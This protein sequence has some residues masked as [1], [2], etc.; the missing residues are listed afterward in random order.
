[1]L[2]LLLAVPPVLAH[3]QVDAH[4]HGL[5]WAQWGL[6]GLWGVAALGWTLWARRDGRADAIPLR[7]RLADLLEGARAPIAWAGLPR[8]LA[9]GLVACLTVREGLDGLDVPGEI[10]DGG[11]SR[12]DTMR[13]N[14]PDAA[15]L[16][17]WAG[18]ETAS[19]LAAHAAATH[20]LGRAILA[21]HA[22]DLA[23]PTTEPGVL[24]VSLD[25]H[26][27]TVVVDHVGGH[28]VKAVTVRPVVG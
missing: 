3:P 26:A 12:V 14:G 17:A 16:L 7:E 8:R 21:V 5:D 24:V 28:T 25:D 11:A 23:L 13:L 10:G 15:R 4:L 9:L 2:S 1:M 22:P 20:A 19:D 27:F 18:S 6:L